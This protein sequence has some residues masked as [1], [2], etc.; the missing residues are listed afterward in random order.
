M[1]NNDFFSKHQ[2]GFRSGLSSVTQLLEVID[3]WTKMLDERKSIDVIYFDFRKAFDTVPHERL[4][5][6]LHS[7]GIRGKI[8]RWIRDFLTNRKQRVILNGQCSKWTNVTS[9]IPQGSVLGPIL[10]LIY[11]NDLPD[12]VNNFIKLFADDTKIICCS[13]CE[14]NTTGRCQ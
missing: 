13:R 2:H 3:D 5:E 7:Y 14:H 9:G 11:I 1:N 8:L 6:K 4:L 12:V 10:F